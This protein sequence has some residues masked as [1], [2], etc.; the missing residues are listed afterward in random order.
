MGPAYKNAPLHPR[1][2]QAS[3]ASGKRPECFGLFGAGLVECIVHRSGH[4]I[5]EHLEVVGIGL[6]LEDVGRYLYADH[7]LVAGHDRFDG[8]SAGRSFD[9]LLGQLVL[10]ALHIGGHLLGLL[11]HALHVLAHVSPPALGRI[12]YRSSTISAPSPF[13]TNS[14]GSCSGAAAPASTE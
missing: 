2:A 11:H 7:A 1:K 4:G 9:L 13:F 6:T 14:T 10:G 5:A 3:H 8:P 12:G